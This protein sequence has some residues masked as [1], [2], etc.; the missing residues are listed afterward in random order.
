MRRGGPALG[1]LLLALAPMV[2][3]EQGAVSVPA[4]GDWEPG[5]SCSLAEP[6]DWEAQVIT[7]GAPPSGH[8]L[9]RRAAAA[10]ASGACL[11]VAVALSNDGSSVVTTGECRVGDRVSSVAIAGAQPDPL[12]GELA[13]HAFI[14]SDA[15]GATHLLAFRGATAVVAVE[16]RGERAF[17]DL[18]LGAVADGRLTT[19]GAFSLLA[20][21]CGEVRWGLYELSLEGASVRALPEL[22]VALTRGRLDRAAVPEHVAWWG[23]V[24]HEDGPATTAWHTLELAS[25]RDEAL[26]H[27]VVDLTLASGPESAHAIAATVRELFEL[28]HARAS[29]A[30]WGRAE[31][32]LSEDA[33]NYGGDVITG[34]SELRAPV[35]ALVDGLGRI[36]A[37][38]REA[39]VFG[40][41]ALDY[42]S[43]APGGGWSLG[44]S[45]AP[46]AVLPSGGAAPRFADI[47]LRDD[48]TVELIIDTSTTYEARLVLLRG[49]GCAA[50]CVTPERL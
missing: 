16:G 31:I 3:C 30:N 17:D 40:T 22:P 44:K 10:G 5:R 48:G 32:T 35:L 33:P 15:D 28:A 26:T 24:Q 6:S 46:Y 13:R 7:F 8:V 43:R 19:G 1:A 34:P 12:G 38:A 9:A 11:A 36:H 29:G 49:A 20:R 21:S 23:L 2:G 37:A 27:D 4:C 41:G 50:R 25:G 39:G 47:A 18:C 45:L 42:G 14:G